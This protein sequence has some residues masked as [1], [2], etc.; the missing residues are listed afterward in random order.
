MSNTISTPHKRTHTGAPACFAKSTLTH[1]TPTK[2]SENLLQEEIHNSPPEKRSRQGSSPNLQETNMEDSAMMKILQQIQ[3]TMVTKDQIHVLESNLKQEIKT[4]IDAKEQIILAEVSAL[5][6]ENQKLKEKLT[7]Q[8]DD[9]LRMQE[10]L[11]DNYLIFSGLPEVSSPNTESDADTKAAVNNIIQ[12]TLKLPSNLCTS[13]KRMPTTGK[14]ARL[15]KI[16]FASHEDRF[17]V[18]SKKQLLPQ[19]QYLNPLEPPQLFDVKSRLRYEC[20][21]NKQQGK[22]AKINWKTYSVEVEN[23]SVHWSEILRE[24]EPAQ[25]NEQ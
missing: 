18:F 15:V 6:E 22:N 9:I 21:R 17:T 16:S 10:H 24:R 2:Q 4:L 8:N 11:N 14:R 13:A 1:R 23:T 25:P 12:H 3:S 5:R 7:K 20:K 19:G